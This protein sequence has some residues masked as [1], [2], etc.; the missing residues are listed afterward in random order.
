MTPE[1]GQDPTIGSPDDT[2][3][4]DPSEA[5]GSTPN[6]DDDQNPW[7]TRFET[8]RTEADRRNTQLSQYEQA[9]EDFR[10]GDPQAMRRAAAI[11]KV[12][13]LLEIPDH[14]PVEYDDPLE[15]MRAEFQTELQ[16]LKGQLSARQEA[17]VHRTIEDRL[18]KLDGLDEEDK[19]LVLAQAM[20]MDP[21]AEGLPDIKA[22]HAALVAR[23]ERITKQYE[24]Q[25]RQG[26]RAPTSIQ[27]GQ[28]ATQQRSIADMTDKDG[29][30]T[31]EGVDYLAQKMEDGQ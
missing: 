17:D 22:A 1:D 18:A 31:Q 21:D 6:W 2:I 28:T 16:A 5:P 29:N 8:Y 27:A 25:W 12:D 19:S 23:D 7:K 24:T 11:L 30:L 14:E 13:E 4:A 26:K 20:R 3:V 15:Q 10:S 9:L